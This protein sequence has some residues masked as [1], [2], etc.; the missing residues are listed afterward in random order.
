MVGSIIL[1][2]CCLLSLWLDLL[3]KKMVAYYP[4]GWICGS[5]IL[6]NGCLLS[7]W[8]DLW[9]YY[10]REW[11]LIIPVVGSVDQLSKRMFAHYPCDWIC[12]SII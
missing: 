9:I 1:E 6:E 4:Y 2:N 12:G 10:L 7:L 5:I 11:L 3:S 8:L